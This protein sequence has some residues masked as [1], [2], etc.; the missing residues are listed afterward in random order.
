[1][2][3]IF[4]KTNISNPLIHNC[5]CAY[6]GVRNVSFSENFASVIHGWPHIRFKHKCLF[7]PLV[8]STKRSQKPVFERWKF[9]YAWLGNGHQALKGEAISI[10]QFH[11][12]LLSISSSLS[13]AVLIYLC[14][15]KNI[16]ENRKI[17][18]FFLKSS[19]ILSCRQK[20]V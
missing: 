1:M 4:R 17:E 19:D 11:I 5:T 14:G 2:H 13:S 6:Q 16:N 18:K 10:S 15:P 12:Y 20:N 3:K 8:V 7:K 9:Q